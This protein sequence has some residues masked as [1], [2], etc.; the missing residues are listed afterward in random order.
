MV[1]T[2][3]IALFGLAIGLGFAHGIEPGHGWPVAATYALDKPNKWASGLLASS[4]LGIG[5][6]ISSIAMV[7]VF[8]WAKT[9][10]NLGQAKWM[11]YVAGILLIL[12]G[13][14]EYRHGHS[15]A[16]SDHSHEDETHSSHTHTDSE[17]DHDHNHDHDENSGKLG[18]LTQYIPFVGSHHHMH[19]EDA[20]R[21]LVG[22]AGFAFVL[23]FAH[24]EEFEIIGL[25]LG[26]QYCLQLMLVYA[27]TVIVGIVGLTLLLIAGYNRYEETVERYATYFPHISAAILIIMGFGFIV[28]LF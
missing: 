4:L 5:H 3:T 18:G 19:K 14:Y 16:E 23:G 9:Y 12:L 8:F 11:N 27:F 15:H 24:E 7:A 1:V 21:G 20:E 25:C 13:V 28:G 17:S 10:F 2:D 22:I 26:S 6:L